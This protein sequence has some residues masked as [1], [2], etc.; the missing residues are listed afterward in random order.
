MSYAHARVM[1]GL[2]SGKIPSS[3]LDRVNRWRRSLRHFRLSLVGL[4]STAYR[5]H[6]RFGICEDWG[7]GRRVAARALTPAG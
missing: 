7:A 2:G 4:G 1:V 3:R 6:D 5:L